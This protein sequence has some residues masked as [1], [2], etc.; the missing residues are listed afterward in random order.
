MLEQNSHING[1]DRDLADKL[2]NLDVYPE[3]IFDLDLKPKDALNAFLELHALEPNLVLKELHRATQISMKNILESY[4]PMKSKGHA[5]DIEKLS[6]QNLDTN[7]KQYLSEM[8]LYSE[9]NAEFGKSYSLAAV[10]GGHLKRFLDRLDHLV[11]QYKIRCIGISKIA[12]LGGERELTDFYGET[13]KALED[14]LAG[15]SL[16]DEPLPRTEKEMMAW[17]FKFSNRVPEKLKDSGN[18]IV[19]D[20]TLREGH[21][22]PSPGSEETSEAL[23][24]LNQEISGDILVCS[25]QPYCRRQALAFA[26]STYLERDLPVT[27][28]TAIGPKPFE[29]KIDSYL[30][31]LFKLI[32]Q[33]LVSRGLERPKF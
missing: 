15:A 16:P 30:L 22:R 12:L 10:Y 20:A 25:S 1:I 32:D 29:E 19:A 18:V 31:E 11:Y 5:I 21:Y 28:I 14:A 24:N 9:L 27:S 6:E 3:S 33:E 7:S 13:P 2:L 8:G 26:K 17:V 23:V 4:E